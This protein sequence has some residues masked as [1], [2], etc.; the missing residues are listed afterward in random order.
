MPK[1]KK[2]NPGS[3]PFLN[4]YL[5][6]K[7]KPFIQAKAEDI[8]QRIL[9]PNQRRYQ[10]IALLVREEFNRPS[11]YKWPLF[12]SAKIVGTVQ[13]RIKRNRIWV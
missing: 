10:E 6:C 7:L 1:K 5:H 2:F 9:L 11:L 12:P 3:I 8:I 13:D 4:M